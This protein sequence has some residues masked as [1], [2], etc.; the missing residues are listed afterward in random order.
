MEVLSRDALPPEREK[1]LRSAGA[2]VDATGRW[3]RV[4]SDTPDSIHRPSIEL[5]ATDFHTIAYLPEEAI[6]EVREVLRD[7][8]WRSTDDPA[9][10]R[11]GVYR[12]SRGH[13][14]LREAGFPVFWRKGESDSASSFELR[15]FQERAG[16]DV[17]VLLQRYDPEH[18]LVERI[19]DN[20]KQTWYR[21]DGL[22][23]IGPP[24]YNKTIAELAARGADCVYEPDLVD[25]AV[26][27]GVDTDSDVKLRIAKD[28]VAN[29]CRFRIIEGSMTM[30][31][32]LADRLSEV[33]EREEDQWLVPREHAVPLVDD[34]R[35][36][37]LEMVTRRLDGRR[38]DYEHWRPNLPMDRGP[39][40][41]IER[42]PVEDLELGE[43]VPGLQ[44]HTVL[45]DHQ[46]RGAAYIRAREYRCIVGDEMGLGKTLT[47]LSAAQYL[48]GPTLVVCPSNARPVWPREIEKWI[49][50]D[51][52]VLSPGDDVQAAYERFHEEG[53]DYTI[54]SYDGL[55]RFYDLIDAIEWDL[56]I[57]DEGHYLRN[58]RT[59]RVQLAR[60][61][62][63]DI[64]R[65]VMLT[66]TPLMNDPSELRS[67]LYFIHPDEWEDATW[68]G[69]RFKKPWERGTPEVREQ[70]V[71]RLHEYLDDVMIRR[72]KSDI[73]H[74]LP[75][76]STHVHHV[77]LTP[78][79]RREYREEEQQYAKEHDAAS[80]ALGSL[81][82]LNRLRQLAVNGK[83]E[84]VIPHIRR[85]L[86]ED[87]KV[88]VF[89]FFLSGL[90]TLKD[91]FAEYEP[92]TLTGSS[93][94]TQ[95][96]QAV[97]RFQTD[98]DC[99][100]F[101]G[102]INAAGQAITLTAARHV[103]F[104]D[105]VWNP[106]VM[107]QAMDRVHRRGQTDD[108]HVHFFVTEDTIEEDIRTVLEEKARLVDAVV[109]DAAFR[110]MEA[111]HWEITERLLDR[112][113]KD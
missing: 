22:L 69:R 90:R 47:S 2:S 101:L 98:D 66:G 51:Y 54:V 39:G 3:L 29:P 70:V 73:F 64:P 18:W 71:E 100:L 19:I 23:M 27:E 65:R 96:K 89:G 108:V 53:W 11:A 52:G 68:F 105:L 45:D 113:G 97:E 80:D 107:R 36:R 43:P 106:S 79:W 5:E 15:H 7:S 9:R 32:E 62:L 104:L 67:L 40:R 109:D 46:G 91:S 49:E 6:A 26:G 110:D 44:P 59:K 14:A 41:P 77:D 33:G 84:D 81:Q 72:V 30:A 61:L 94:D 38:S 20:A 8:R 21:E 85:L 34:L 86:G 13:K 24:A 103:V 78:G 87:E 16:G 1:E 93:S 60:E 48:D 50:A 76:K 58:R 4:P 57:I 56:V 31:K 112:R 74:E 99:R 25:R 28:M 75:D 42:D 10:Y 55:D 82:R 83:L 95:R 12:L 102:Q 92:A 88:V 35:E 17:M 111:V 37:G 63:L